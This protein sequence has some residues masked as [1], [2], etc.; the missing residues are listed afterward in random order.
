MKIKLFYELPND[1]AD[2]RTEVFV[3]EQGFNEEFDGEDKNALHLVGY[4]GED[5]VATSRILKQDKSR[6][7]IGRI[8]VRKQFRG[9]GLGAK[10]VLA[11]E[12]CIKKLGG[13]EIFIHSQMR[14]ASFYEKI[15]YLPTGDF[16]E[17][18]G[19]PHCMMK[20]SL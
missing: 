5:A 20:K 6:Y 17:E 13:N 2:I 18:E 3:D 7:M 12:D 1:A 15:G 16:D 9:R 11:A 19:C 14:A 8:A 10:I 4:I